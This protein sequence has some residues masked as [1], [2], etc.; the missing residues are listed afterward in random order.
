MSEPIE[1]YVLSEGYHDRAFW[2]GQL[3]HLGCTDP[4]SRPNGPRKEVYDPFGLPVRGGHFAFHSRSGAFIRIVQAGG[5]NQVRQLLR[6][7]LKESAIKHL[8][9]LVVNV[10]SDQFADGTPPVG[11]HLT[12]QQLESLAREFDDHATTNADGD[13]EI[14]GGETKISLVRWQALDPATPGIPHQQTLERLICAALLAVYQNRGPAVQA[15]LDSRPDGPVAGPKEYAWSYLAGW[16]A[17]TGSYEGFCSRLWNNAEIVQQL[18]PRLE[19][20]GTWRVAQAL[21]A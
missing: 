13:I 11:P 16:Y 1:S 21:A 17:D 6:T 10:D 3:L 12:L 7:R 15:W 8:A 4:G 5:K 2:A 19:A 9:R 14:Y 20:S 18:R